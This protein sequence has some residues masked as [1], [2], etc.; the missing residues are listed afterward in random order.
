MVYVPDRFMLYGR[1]FSVT[2][3]PETLATVVPDGM[4][5][6]ETACPAATFVELATA[7]LASEAD[8]VAVKVKFVDTVAAA[9]ITN[10]VLF[11]I[12]LM[13][14]LVGTPNP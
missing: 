2:V 3:V 12:E 9:L 8:G 6:P 1:W 13:V 10:E 7:M 14:A 5:G 4:Y 11:V